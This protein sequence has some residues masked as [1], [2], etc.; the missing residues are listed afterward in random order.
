MKWACAPDVK[1]AGRAAHRRATAGA[2]VHEAPRAHQHLSAPAIHRTTRPQSTHMSVKQLR[3][4]KVARSQTRT[5][6]KGKKERGSILTMIRKGCTKAEPMLVCSVSRSV[7]SHWAN[8]G[9][10]AAIAWLA[11]WIL[12]RGHK[13]WISTARFMCSGKST[14][15]ALVSYCRG[16]S[17]QSPC[18]QYRSIVLRFCYQTTHFHTFSNI[19]PVPSQRFTYP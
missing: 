13:P 18:I 16:G 8:H 9:A 19:S 11:A 1:D 10:T 2:R 14:Q 6:K 3:N 5:K 7:V 17:E 12:A 4:V 15:K